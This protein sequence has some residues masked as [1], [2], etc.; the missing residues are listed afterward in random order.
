MSCRILQGAVAA[1]LVPNLTQDYLNA[2]GIASRPDVAVERAE[3]VRFGCVLHAKLH[4][5]LFGR[6]VPTPPSHTAP[7][8]AERIPF[9]GSFSAGPVPGRYQ[10]TDGDKTPHPEEGLPN[11]GGGVITAENVLS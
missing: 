9:L 1:M 10:L 4:L 11:A 3:R 5:F 7:E 8:I 6:P 2:T